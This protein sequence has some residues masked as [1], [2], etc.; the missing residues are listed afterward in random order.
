[1]IILHE[2]MGMIPLHEPY[3][4]MGVPLIED[5]T[6]SLGSFLDADKPGIRG[7]IVLCA[8]EEE[9]MISSAGGS[10]IMTNSKDLRDSWT[11]LLEGV[12]S[13]VEMPDMN[14]ALGIIQC[15]TFSEQLEKRRT[16]YRLF[17]K[18]LLKTRHK[19]FGIS[20]LEYEVNGY[21][22]AVLLDSKIEDVMKFATKYQVSS[23]KTFA[24][25]AG[26]DKSDDFDHFPNAIPAMLRCI[27]FPLYPFISQS[28]NDMLVKVI[29]HLP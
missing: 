19:V 8:F 25:C 29:S 22:F 13:Y 15:A 18:S 9:D 10:V 11:P 7:D 16:F 28:D 1:M 4:D 17:Q 24:G 2:P 21:G 12:R 26:A 20:A 27:S 3:K 6:E 14:A 23:Q 5:M